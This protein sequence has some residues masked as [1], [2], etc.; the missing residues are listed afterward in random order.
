MITEGYVCG[1]DVSSIKLD[2]ALYC[3]TK[4]IRLWTVKNNEAGIMELVRELQPVQPK[5][6]VLE[7]TGGYEK[8]ATYRIYE[9]GMKVA[10]VNPRHTHHF[11]KSLGHLAKQDSID[12][13]MLA[14]YAIRTDVKESVLKDD[15][16]RAFSATLSRRRELVDMRTAEMNRL[17]LCHI[18]VGGQIRRHIEWLTREIEDCEKEMRGLVNNM[19]VWKANVDILKSAIGVADTVSF[20]L[21]A[22][23]PELG[24]L[25][26]KEIAALVGVAPY[27][28]DSGKR[29]GKRSCRGGR[30][31]VRTILYNATLAAIRCAGPIKEFYSKKKAEGKPSKV[32]I[33][34]AMRKLVIILN[35][36]L[37]DQK[38]FQK[39]SVA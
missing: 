20:T 28:D 34:A 8:E 39:P 24:Q 2:V 13:R 10:V 27:N 9:A 31:N 37:R 22:Y 11:A 17:K 1:I 7:S 3:D 30:A 38:K 5:L 35:A 12:A 26:A 25:T 4:F 19:P 33:V 29:T 16:T 18:K 14:E 23:L 6:V 15:E 32:A 21:L 36:M